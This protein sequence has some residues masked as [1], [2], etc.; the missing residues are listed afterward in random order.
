VLLYVLQL[1]LILLCQDFELL[2]VPLLHLLLVLLML[3]FELCALPLMS[4]LLLSQL[5]VLTHALLLQAVNAPI[6]TLL[7]VIL[8]LVVKLH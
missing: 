4:L 3:L 6:V 8:L 2:L 5:L 1:L 7:Q